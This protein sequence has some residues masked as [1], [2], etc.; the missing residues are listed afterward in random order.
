M[1]APKDF[2][3]VERLQANNKIHAQT[4]D[5]KAKVIPSSRLAV[6]A[7]M[8]SRVNVFDILGLEDG[9]AHII[10]NAGGIITE[11]AIRSLTLSQHLLGTREVIIMHHTDCGLHMLSSHDFK[12]SLLELVGVTPS[13]AVEGFDDP[14]VDVQQ[15]IRRIRATPFIPYTDH[16]YGFV[17]DVASGELNEVECE[18]GLIRNNHIAISEMA[19]ENLNL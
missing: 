18:L 19:E 11:D 2:P 3:N 13:W 4:R 9:E 8:D 15:S 5:S 16:V 6:V 1:N 12:Q 14:Y 7:C 10:R 17:Y